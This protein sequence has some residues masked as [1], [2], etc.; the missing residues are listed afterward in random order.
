MLHFIQIYNNYFNH[1]HIIT[2]VDVHIKTFSK[3]M[4]LL[5]F[6]SVGFYNRPNSYL[7]ENNEHQITSENGTANFQVSSNINIL[8]GQEVEL[9]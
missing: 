7:W 6:V 8:C 4:I 2:F 1:F 3:G 5:K 9:W